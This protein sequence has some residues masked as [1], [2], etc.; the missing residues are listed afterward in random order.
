MI[1]KIEKFG[2]NLI[3]RPSGKE[4]F[5][6][7][8][9]ELDQIAKNEEVLIDFEG[10]TVLTPSWA[11]EFV[12]PIQEKFKNKVKLVNTENPSVKAT[13]K[14]LEKAKEARD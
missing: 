9:F 8:K 6:A 12:T 5:L 7:F 14:T 4:A 3:S 1:I 2:T 11:D 10:V 13:L